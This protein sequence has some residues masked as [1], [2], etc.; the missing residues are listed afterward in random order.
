[1]SKLYTIQTNVPICPEC[2][3]GLKYYQIM[4]DYR[5]I[6]CGAR[7]HVVGYGKTEREF[8]CER[9]IVVNQYEN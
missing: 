4:Q 3:G 8:I 7:Y 2:G 9:R 6:H 1:M 5:C